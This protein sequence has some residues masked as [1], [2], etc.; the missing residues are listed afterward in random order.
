MDV[1]LLYNESCLETIQRLPEESIDLVVTSPPY[2]NAREYSQYSSLKE[3][4]DFIQSVFKQLYPKI[5]SGGWVCVNVSN[6]LDGEGDRIPLPMYLLGVLMRVGFKFKEDVTW[7]KPEG[8][9]IIRGNKQS[10][11]SMQHCPTWVKEYI[12]VLKKQGDLGAGG[13]LTDVENTDFWY[14][15]PVTSKEHTAPFPIKLVE[16]CIRYWS[17][18]GAVVYDPFI[19]SGTTALACIKNN[20]KF[21]GSELNKEYFDLCMRRVFG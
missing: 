20:R 12:L 9:G 8:G 3:Y 2:Y 7:V 21:I 19:G 5:K 6:V 15:N 4:L 14:I 11:K 16:N 1:N 10:I 13:V 17:K 18:E